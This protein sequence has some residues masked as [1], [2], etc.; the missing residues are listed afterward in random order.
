MEESMRYLFY[1]LRNPSMTRES[2]PRRR[3]ACFLVLPNTCIPWMG[4]AFPLKIC[5]FGSDAPYLVHHFTSADQSDPSVA[6]RGA[7][8]AANSTSLIGRPRRSVPAPVRRTSSH[9]HQELQ[10]RQ[11]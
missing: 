10:F 6:V 1:V 3:L 9:H 8:S 2:C 4:D 7:S 5:L 11:N